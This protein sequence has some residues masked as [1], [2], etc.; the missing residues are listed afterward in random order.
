MYSYDVLAPS[1]YVY[2]LW[3][4]LETV[5]TTRSHSVGYE[6]V[7]VMLYSKYCTSNSYVICTHAILALYISTH[8]Y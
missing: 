1:S 2:W 5:V 6:Y 3:N 4:L 8:N 7:I